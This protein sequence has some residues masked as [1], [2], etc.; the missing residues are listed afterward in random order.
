V[1]Q[2]VANPHHNTLFLPGDRACAEAVKAGPGSQIS[3]VVLSNLPNWRKGVPQMKDKRICG[4]TLILRKALSE[5]ST[6]DRT[7]VDVVLEDEMIELM[8]TPGM[9][10]CVGARS[11]VA[12]TIY[13]PCDSSFNTL[14]LRTYLWGY[15]R[16]TPLADGEPD[17]PTFI[18]SGVTDLKP[19]GYGPDHVVACGETADDAARKKAAYVVNRLMDHVRALELAANDVTRAHVYTSDLNRDIIRDHLIEAFPRLTLHGITFV[20]AQ[21]FY[22]STDARHEPPKLTIDVSA[23]NVLYERWNGEGNELSS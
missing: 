18:V 16:V 22:L 15:W 5:E 21:T 17:R 11:G 7:L 1:S 3:Q 2:L 10:F 8:E 9:G 4:L 6:N 20:D 23:G 14:R 12:R 13:T 19:G